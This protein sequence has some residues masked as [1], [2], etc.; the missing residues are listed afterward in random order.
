M[1][2]LLINPKIPE[3]VIEEQCLTWSSYQKNH[4]AFK[5]KDQVDNSRFFRPAY[6][7]KFS[8]NGV[9]DIIVLMKNGDTLFIE[10]KSR[11][12]QQTKD[13]KYFQKICE[14]MG[15]NYHIV[16]SL[17]EYRYLIGIYSS[18]IV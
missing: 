12:G 5:V 11:E 14:E 3:K 6:I 9:S 7:K 10:I 2:K 15:Q 17:D 8:I 18:P 16:R 4:F 13:Q 1:K